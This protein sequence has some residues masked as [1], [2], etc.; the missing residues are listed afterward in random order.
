MGWLNQVYIDVDS[1]CLSLC[2]EG[3]QALFFY[4]GCLGAIT[5]QEHGTLIL[6]GV[7]GHS[8]SA[9]SCVTFSFPDGSFT[10]AM[11][12]VQLSA[13]APSCPGHKGLGQFT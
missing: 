5:P 6:A 9:D 13:E 8:I 3:G 2:M 7:A 11:E 1:N 12:S 10:A 4:V